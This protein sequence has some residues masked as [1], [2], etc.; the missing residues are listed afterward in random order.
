MTKLS[1][2]DAGFLYAETETCPMNIASVQLLE[3]PKGHEDSFDI[4]QFVDSLRD[5]I[6]QRID[7][8]PYLTAVVEHTSGFLDH[9]NWI[10]DDQF[11]ICNHIY[12]VAVAAPGDQRQLEHTVA[13]LHQQ[14]LPRNRP[15]WDIVVLTGLA[16]G[17]I[18]LYNRVHH[19]CLDGMAAQAANQRLMDR[20]PDKPGQ[21]TPLPATTGP[22]R[23]VGEHTLS[24]MEALLNQAV[25]TLVTAPAAA[26]ASQKLWQR[27]FHPIQ[28][29]GAFGTPAPNTLLNKS[30]DKGRAYAM[31]ELPL[32]TVKNMARCTK[33]TVNDVF[34]SLCG[35]ALRQYLQRHGN[36]P[37]A[38]LLAGCPV[39]L[40]KAGDHKNNNQ[41]AMMKVTIASDEAD[42][43]VR[44]QAVNASATAAKEVLA[45]A[46]DLIP[47]NITLPG[48][49]ANIHRNAV[50]ANLAPI[51]E[52][53]TP[54]INVL[55]SNV[56][57]PRQPLYINGARM[58]SHYPVS[59]VTQ[60]MALNITVQSYDGKLFFG[61]TACART[62]PD[63]DLLRDDL[64]AEYQALVKALSAEIVDLDP[65]VNQTEI[66]VLM[67]LDDQPETSRV[68]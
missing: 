37:K 49:G 58:L 30:I 33:A 17:Q 53:T 16:N 22:H 11:D 42:P 3:L 36:L 25:E 52:W 38:S 54:R 41:M 4:N 34:V 7:L 19:A 28:G 12:P 56:P 15:L 57:G 24:M 27:S 64:L 29:L 6:S 55:I 61:L 39:S 8:V 9:P 21:L 18:A 60:G 1:A 32:S 62:I 59:I 35:G 46:A 68:A 67:E 45:E 63:V 13:Q 26:L 48:M 51:A 47:A 40:R 66:P 65:T 2:T 31:G 23:N 10:K 20:N 44:L 14:V 43:V 50:L 5:F